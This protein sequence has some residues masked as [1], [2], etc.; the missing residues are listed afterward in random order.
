MAHPGSADVDLDLARSGGAVGDPAGVQSCDG[1]GLL[2]GLNGN[3]A[4]TLISFGSGGFYF[5]FLAVALVAPHDHPR[6]HPAH[7]TGAHPG[8]R[9][10]RAGVRAGGVRRVGARVVMSASNM[11]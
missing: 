11:P 8:P 9:G 1:V 7:T 5:I 10:A 3:A 6:A 4:A 2:L